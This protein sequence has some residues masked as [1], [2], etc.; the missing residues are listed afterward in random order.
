MPRFTPGQRFGQ[1]VSRFAGE[2]WRKFFDCL[3]LAL[4]L[5]AEV[6]ERA[7]ERE[8]TMFS[9]WVVNQLYLS[10]RSVAA[11]QLHR[12]LC[13]FNRRARDSRAVGEVSKIS[14]DCPPASAYA[15]FR[16]PRFCSIGCLLVDDEVERHV[17][18]EQLG[19]L[20]IDVVSG[21]DHSRRKLHAEAAIYAGRCER[22]VFDRLHQ[23]STLLRPLLD[24]LVEEMPRQPVHL[25]DVA[26]VRKRLCIEIVGGEMID[27]KST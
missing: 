20:A 3:D 5:E 26:A 12:N 21:V 22:G 16:D 18:R 8:R 24:A 1:Q 17:L 27:R 6:V 10:A 25:S 4:Q 13:S 7:L 23:D 9:P 11:N 19:E 15:R 2:L 14:R